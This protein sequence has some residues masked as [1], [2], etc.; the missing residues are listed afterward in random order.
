[1]ET[2]HVWRVFYFRRMQSFHVVAAR[3]AAAPREPGMRGGPEPRGRRSANG[4][5]LCTREI[6][7]I[8][9]LSAADSWPAGRCF[10]DLGRGERGE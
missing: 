9:L 4:I 7:V 5:V 2:S 8:M 1:M 10:R 3:G 6:T